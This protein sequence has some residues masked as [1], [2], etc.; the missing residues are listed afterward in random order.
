MDTGISGF[1]SAAL[2]VGSST[3]AALAVQSTRHRFAGNSVIYYQDDPT[4]HIHLLLSGYVRLSYISEDGFVTLLS[5][6]PLGRSFGESGI[7]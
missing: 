7:L 4:T 2:G 3:A 1:I 6:I 5:I